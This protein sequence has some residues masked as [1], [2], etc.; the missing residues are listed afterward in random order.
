MTHTVCLQAT[1]NRLMLLS[2]KSRLIRPSTHVV[3]N[4]Q[5]LCKW[6][7]SDDGLCNETER[8]GNGSE[9]RHSRI[10]Y[11]HD[12]RRRTITHLYAIFRL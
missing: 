12:I 11:Q 8:Y 9:L 10:L 5:H 1:A 7:V 6:S 4:K 3:S 2:S